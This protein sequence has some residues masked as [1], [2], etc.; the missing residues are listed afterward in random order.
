MIHSSKGFPYVKGS[1]KY[2]YRILRQIQKKTD[3]RNKKKSADGQLS[4]LLSSFFWQLR[5]GGGVMFELLKD[6]IFRGI[7]SAAF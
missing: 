7:E 4:S 5:S 6:I 2:G 3:I 1:A